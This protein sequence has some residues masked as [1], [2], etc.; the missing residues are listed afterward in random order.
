MRILLMTLVLVFSLFAQKSEEIYT[1]VSEE[2]KKDLL[3]IKVKQ[4]DYKI[5]FTAKGRIGTY[6]NRL[7]LGAKVLLEDIPVYEIFL[8]PNLS[9]I[10]YFHFQVEYKNKDLGDKLEVTQ[11]DNNGLELTQT[12]GLSDEEVNPSISL[13]N[14]NLKEFYQ[15][16][17]L[18]TIKT[19]QEGIKKLYGL[20][21]AVENVIEVKVKDIGQGQISFFIN[22]KVDLK[23]ITI[24]KDTEKNH[25]IAH[26]KISAGAENQYRLRLMLEKRGCLIDLPIIDVGQGRDGIL[27]KTME[28]ITYDKGCMDHRDL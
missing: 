21:K 28:H 9:I 25:I 11:I 5:R 20:E 22:T 14:R 2:V 3:K 8:N 12:L 18:W 19:Y 6:Q 10:P 13:K 17:D 24:F 1:I 26:M 4:I 7:L 15:T 16:Q 23:S 27:Y